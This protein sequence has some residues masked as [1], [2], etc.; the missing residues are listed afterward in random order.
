MI[1][2]PFAAWRS[3]GH[4]ADIVSVEIPFAAAAIVST[5]ACLGGI[6][7]EVSAEDLVWAAELGRDLEAALP[8]Q[9]QVVKSASDQH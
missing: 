7:E 4:D 1:V 9:R 6:V 8:R 3:S 2:L 5:L